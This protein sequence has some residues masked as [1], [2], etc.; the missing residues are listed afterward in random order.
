MQQSLHVITR[1]E[2][3]QNLEIWHYVNDCR[4]LITKLRTE[5]INLNDH[6]H[7]RFKDINNG[8][9]E[10]CKY[11]SVPETVEHYLIDCLG[12]TKKL[13]LEMNSWEINFN[14][15]RNILK[16][17]LKRIDSFFN[18][19]ANFNV[20]NLLFPHVWQVKPRRKDIN[21]KTKIENGTKRRICIFKELTEFVY[22]IQKDLNVKNLEY[23]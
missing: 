16:C 13:A 12:Q 20:I 21:Y 7:F 3:V 4:S 6:K 17:K 1:G 9:Y 15:S 14:A 11:C 22:R 5:C 18:N 2:G 8:H 19:R 23:E 10:M